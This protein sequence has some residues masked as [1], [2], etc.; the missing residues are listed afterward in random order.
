MT[1]PI[2]YWDEIKR[3]LIH[4][5]S[6]WIVAMIIFL[7]R[8]FYYGRWI[9]CAVLFGCLFI[10]LILEHDYANNGKYLGK[11]YGKLFRSMLRH[12]V[13]PGQ[14]IVSGGAPVLAAALLINLLFPPAIAAAALAVMLAGDAFA[15]LI[16][17]K[18]GKHPLVNGKSLEGT[19]S[20]IVAGYIAL[21]IVA[22][23]C[24][25]SAAF[26]LWGIAGTVLGA[27]AEL[28]TKQLKIDDNFTIPLAV[29]GI[30]C[31]TLL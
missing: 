1:A 7:P 9:A 29:S 15:A 24:N 30:L 12:E 4:L 11:L 23:L 26:Y 5:S 31:L 27:A 21:A 17:R 19:V 14:W 2:S 20:F 28:F 6:F 22:L 18:F 25:A 8:F 3:K 16:G 13:V 10:T